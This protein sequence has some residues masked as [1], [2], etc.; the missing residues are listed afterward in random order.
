L[1]P[2]GGGIY[3]RAGICFSSDVEEKSYRPWT[4][5]QPYLLP[6]SPM[7]W[8]PSKHLAYFVLDVVEQ[9]NLG[10]IE[11]EIQRKDHRG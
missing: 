1:Q 3:I 11:Q 2:R 8:L 7:D 6:P 4:P 10:E 9:L 5:R